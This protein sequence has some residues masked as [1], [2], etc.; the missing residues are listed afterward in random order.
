MDQH[1]DS[2]ANAG[3]TR[4]QLSILRE[5]LEE[6]RARLLSRRASDEEVVREGTAPIEPM[7]AAVRS[8]DEDDAI[9]AVDRERALLSD[10]EDALARMEDGRYGLSETSGQPIG[11]RRLQAVPW[12]RQTADEEESMEDGVEGRV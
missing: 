10:V 9:L 2:E 1:L 3:L 4:E 5:K 6:T 11:F 8:R 7:E 12:A